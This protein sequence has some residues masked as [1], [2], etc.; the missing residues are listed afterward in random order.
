VCSRSAVES[1]GFASAGSTSANV[2]AETAAAKGATRESGFSWRG[3]TGKP[4]PLRE[5]PSGEFGGG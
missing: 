4:L 3:L 5:A 2:E 1:R